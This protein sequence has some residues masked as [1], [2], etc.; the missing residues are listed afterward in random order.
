MEGGFGIRES[1]ENMRIRQVLLKMDGTHIDSSRDT[2][3]G[4]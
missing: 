4:K 3:S 1:L 2:P